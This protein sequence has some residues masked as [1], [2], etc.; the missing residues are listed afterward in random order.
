MKFSIN[1]IARNAVIAALYVV[2]TLLAYP[3]SFAAIQVRIA[4]ILVILCFFRK[5]YVI[6]LT[7]GC[8]IAN[9]FSNVGALDILFGTLATLL[10]CLLISFS[11][12]LILAI[13]FPVVFNGFIVAF[14]IYLLDKSNTLPYIYLVIFIAAGELITMIVAYIFAFLFKKKKH[15]I[16]LIGAN[17][18]IDFKF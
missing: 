16:D 3:I 9:C 13:M 15:F 4:E 5:D 1:T 11:K 6:G 18:N 17:Q 14:E 8:L 7:L 12:Y 2:L 10:S